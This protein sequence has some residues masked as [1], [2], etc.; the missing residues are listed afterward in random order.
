M[1]STNRSA[2]GYVS[3]GVKKALLT[4]DPDGWPRLHRYRTEGQGFWSAYY[5]GDLHE[6]RF[7]AALKASIDPHWTEALRYRFYAHAKLAAMTSHIPGDLLFAGV[8][9]GGTAKCVLGYL[10]DRASG[11]TTY[12]VDAWEGAMSRADRRV[13]TKFET[14]LNAVRRGFSAFSHVKFLKGYIPDVLPE[15]EAERLSFVGLNT[16]DP[17]SECQSLPTFWERMSIGA[18]ILINSYAWRSADV[19]AYNA[20]IYQLPGAEVLNLLNGFGAVMKTA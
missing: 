8:S 1:H 20:V 9:H 12:L 6:P 14:D 5:P 4:I 11:K 18:I 13:N 15:L 16:T 19:T 7:D 10:G 17:D 2:N 3:I